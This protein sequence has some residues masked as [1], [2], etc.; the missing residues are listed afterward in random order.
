MLREE[1]EEKRDFLRTLPQSYARLTIVEARSG[2]HTLL[3]T[4]LVE[5]S[6]STKTKKKGNI[7]AFSRILTLR[8][9]V[10]K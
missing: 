7:L 6:T 9:K 2:V 3:D 4:S 5:N 8:L 1:K 10:G